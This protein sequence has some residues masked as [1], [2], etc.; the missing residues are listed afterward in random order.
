MSAFGALCT[1]PW[2]C[3]SIWPTLCCFEYCSFIVSIEIQVVWGQ[4][5]TKEEEVREEKY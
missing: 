1:V 4:W 5:R 3:A 2:V